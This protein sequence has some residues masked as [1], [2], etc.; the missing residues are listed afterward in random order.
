MMHTPISIQSHDVSPSTVLRRALLAITLL[1]LMTFETACGVVQTM[2]LSTASSGR[3]LVSLACRGPQSFRGVVN[4]QIG[5]QSFSLVCTPR[6]TQVEL[7]LPRPTDPSWTVSF[8]IM[9]LESQQTCGPIVGDRIPTS[10]HCVFNAT[11]MLLD[12]RWQ[13]PNDP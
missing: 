13:R 7:P 10:M 6:T 4:G 1:A 2:T 11:T 9:E 5:D 12:L 3:A 8:S